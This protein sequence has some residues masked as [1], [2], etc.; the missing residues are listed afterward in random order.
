MS[1]NQ[2]TLNLIK[3]VALHFLPNCEVILF[4]SRA[5]KDFR[6]DSDY[7][8][9]IISEKTLSINKKMHYKSKIRK[10]L[11]KQ[12]IVADILLN[13]KE[14]V[15]KKQN[16]LGHIVREVMKEGIFL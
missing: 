5:K 11:V 14:E 7:D 16:L 13:S 12:N 3:S 15:D 9:M 10:A 8:I 4:G 1:N 6:K 2:T